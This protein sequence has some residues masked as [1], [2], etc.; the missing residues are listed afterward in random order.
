MTGGGAKPF[1]WAAAAGGRDGRATGRCA[2]VP[3]VKLKLKPSR[4]LLTVVVIVGLVLVALL[5]ARSGRRNPAAGL[6]AP[7]ER[8]CSDF[9]AGYPHAKSK[10]ARLALADKVTRSSSQ[11]R[12]ATIA[13][14][15][16]DVGRNAGG[17]EA[18][19]TASADA[20][21]AACQSA[22]WKG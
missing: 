19:W 18:H 9:A 6:D 21:T 2:S 5:V 22:G 4:K 16:A 13:K 17:T 3:F 10:S 15:A 1:R 20:L 12:N 8:A 11:S 14:R 7:A